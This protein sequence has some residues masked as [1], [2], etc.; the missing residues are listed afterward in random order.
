AAVRATFD[1]Q[2]AIVD[3]DYERAFQRV[4]GAKRAFVLVLTD[5]LDEAAA[6]SLAEALPVLARRHAVI[7]ASATDPDVD[8]LL[9]AAPPDARPALPMAAALALRAPR[10]RAAAPPRASGAPFIVAPPPPLSPACV[11]AYPAAKS[12]A[13]L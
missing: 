13:R 11:R 10:A 8:A 7:V 4:G 3:S 2:A 5:L 1:L 6:R 12:R 9:G